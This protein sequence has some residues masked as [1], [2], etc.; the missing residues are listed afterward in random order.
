MTENNN[1]DKMAQDLLGEMALS[2][3]NTVLKFIADG[4]KE[5]QDTIKVPQE[6]TDHLLQ[7][8]RGYLLR[9]YNQGC[10]DGMGY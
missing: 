8:T 1:L 2:F 7:R 9:A 6:I 10:S 5:G 3:G 4:A